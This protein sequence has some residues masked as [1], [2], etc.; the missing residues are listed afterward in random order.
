MGGPGEGEASVSEWAAVSE[1]RWNRG[2][3]T[4]SSAS[5]AVMKPSQLDAVF[6]KL[7][8]V[9]WPLFEAQSCPAESK[10]SPYAL[11]SPVAKMS[12]WQV[13]SAPRPFLCLH[14]SFLSVTPAGRKPL[15]GSQHGAAVTPGRARSCGQVTGGSYSPHEYGADES[16]HL[17][18]GSMPPTGVTAQSPCVAGSHAGSR[19]SAQRTAPERSASGRDLNSFFHTLVGTPPPVWPPTLLF[20]V[21]PPLLPVGRSAGANTQIECV[22]ISSTVPPRRAGLQ[23]AVAS[24]CTHRPR[25]PGPS[26]DLPQRRLWRG[27][28]Y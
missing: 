20:Q 14:R 17:S 23:A 10:V 1:G 2:A 21:S 11:R 7:P 12:T 25:R 3:L 16:P 4:W 26:S 28:R 5:V 27:S 22:E 18:R 8:S 6:G 24:A 13:V 15:A 19:A 9:L